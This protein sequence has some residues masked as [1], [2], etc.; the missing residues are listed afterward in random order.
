[1][2]T[3]V[4]M[5]CGE[6]GIEFQVPAPWQQERKENGKTWFCPNG[7]SRVYRESDADALRRERDQLVQRIAQKD[8]EIR[9]QREMRDAA[10]RRVSAAKGQITRLKKRAANGVCPCCNRSF[11]DLH[12]H[13]QTKHAGYIAEPVDLDE[14][15]IQ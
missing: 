14:A 2:T 10:E 4:L 3:F 12:K 8:D 11:A 5:C 15:I 9:H 1:M 13:M 7:H 6:C